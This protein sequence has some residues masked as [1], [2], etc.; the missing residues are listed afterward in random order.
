MAVGGASPGTGAGPCPGA[1]AGA[2]TAA[3]GFWGGGI[4]EGVGPAALVLGVYSPELAG[5]DLGA[6]KG[7]SSKKFFGAGGGA[8]VVTAGARTGC[9]GGGIADEAGGGIIATGGG[10]GFEVAT[11]RRGRDKSSGRS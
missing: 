11:G 6:G 1:G 9:A 2:G 5:R 4:W 8:A 10:A 3:Y 7:S